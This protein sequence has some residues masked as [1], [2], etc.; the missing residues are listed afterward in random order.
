[1]R[2]L[3]R[4]CVTPVKGMALHHPADV[5]LGPTGIA[6]NRRFYFV[7]RFAELFS[8]SDDGRLVQVVPD[9]DPST[10]HL[11]LRFPDG[12]HIDGNAD[13]PGV[14][15]LTDF[16]GRPVPAHE[17][18]GE[19]GRAVSSFMGLDLTMLRCDQDGAGADVEPLTLVS[20]A[21]VADL[22]RRGRRDEALDSRRFRL[23]LELEGCEPYD[24]DAWEGT[25]V[26]VGDAVLRVL[27]QV[28]RCVVTTQ[29]PDTGI[30]D[31]NTL[32]Q[33]AKYRPRIKGDGGLPFGMYARVESSARVRRGSSVVPLG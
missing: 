23:N 1:M 4:I 27:G 19:F 14:A 3:G 10:E 25:R 31:W 7:D 9:Y 6:E 30:K 16:Y 13:V 33:I 24:E 18:V 2:T 11:S 15:H 29:S 12:V 22:A 28:P 20:Y 26:Q 8:G 5:L 17:V 32:T 21:S